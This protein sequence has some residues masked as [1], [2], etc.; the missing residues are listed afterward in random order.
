MAGGGRLPFW[1]VGSRFHFG[2]RGGASILAGFHFGRG[3]GRQR[4]AKVGGGLPFWQV[5]GERSPLALRHAATHTFQN[6]SPPPPNASQC[7]PMP[8]PKWKP[9]KMA[10]PPRLPKWQQPP[11]FQNGSHPPPS[12]LAAPFVA[13]SRDLISRP[14]VT[15]L[16]PPPL[17]PLQ[18]PCYQR[19]A[20]VRTASG[21]GAT[22]DTPT[23]RFC[24][25]AE[26]R[27]NSG[28][29]ILKTGGRRNFG[30]LQ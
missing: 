23:V 9:S 4:S 20:D 8:L 3:K 2:R 14:A 30:R 26:T 27:T 21:G 29:A 7:R 10:A 22:A 6:G 12:I 18:K 19:L 13:T 1:Q 15:R 24:G 17:P 16:K 11:T 25:H 28:F 5:C